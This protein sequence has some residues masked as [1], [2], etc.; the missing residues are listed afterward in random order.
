METCSII[1]VM[2]LWQK[3]DGE[4]STLSVIDY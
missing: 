3:T 4:H 2:S 1:V